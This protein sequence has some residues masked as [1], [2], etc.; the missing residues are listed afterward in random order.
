[1]PRKQL[2]SKDKVDTKP[3]QECSAEENLLKEYKVTITET[4]KKDVYVEAETRH[5]AEQKVFDAWRNSEHILDAD[6][7]I[8][9]DFDAEDLAP[10]VEMSY[11]ELSALFRSVNDKAL[12]HITGYVVFTSDSFDKPY[13]EE[14]RTYQISS[15]NKAYQSGMGSYSIYASCLDGTDPCLRLD[16]YMR[17]EDAWRIEK[18][19]MLKD[20]YNKLMTQLSPC[21]QFRPDK[22]AR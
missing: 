6:N 5:E 22:D 15:N 7:F 18:C 21:V 3:T 11:S 8:D 12:P 4:L 17:G 13:N 19:Y 9:A 10:K 20:D 2:M 14:S 16:G 1:M